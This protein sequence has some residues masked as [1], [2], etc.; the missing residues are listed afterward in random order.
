MHP[1]SCFAQDQASIKDSTP[2]DSKDLHC[3]KPGHT[4]SPS[5]IGKA[6]AALLLPTPAEPTWGV[7]GG[8]AWSPGSYS[9]ARQASVAADRS[10]LCRIRAP[11]TVAASKPMDFNSL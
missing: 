2:K 6:F 5:N 3:T 1:D 9:E 10:D 11:V 7:E 4:P 8:P